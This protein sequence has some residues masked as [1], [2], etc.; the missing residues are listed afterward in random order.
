MGKSTPGSQQL[1][2]LFMIAVISGVI[3]AGVLTNITLRSIEKNLP[4]TLLIELNDLSLALENLS[5]IVN[6]ANSAK[7]DPKP[8]NFNILRQKVDGGA[9]DI[10]RMRE[11]Y[12][13]DN[14][15]NASAFHAVTAPA[16]ADLKIWLSDGISG[17]GPET[18]T[19]AVIA[20][21]RIDVA[22]QKARSLNRNSRSKAQAILTDQR[23]RIDHFLVNVN[24]LFVLTMLITLSMVYLLARQYV[25]QK[26]EKIAQEE[27]RGQRDLLNS[28]FENVLLGITVWDHD[29][30]LL[31]LNRGFTDI[32]GYSMSDI[33]KQSDWLEAAY[34][35]SIYRDRVLAAWKDT[36]NQKNGIHEFKVV[37]KSDKVKDV[38][39]RTTFLQDG[40]ALVTMSD[41]SDRKRTERM[42]K[43]SQ[44]IKA[45]AKKMESLGLLAG[46]VAHDLNNVLTGIVSY[47][48][49][50]LLNLPEESELRGPIETIKDAGHRAA[51]IVLDLLTVARGVATEKEPLGLNQLITDYLQTPEY[52]KLKQFHPSVT[53]KTLFDKSLRNINGS[54]VHIRKSIMNLVSNASEAIGG[55][56]IVTIS[57]KNKY[58]D[59]PLAGYDDVQS[60][61]YVVLSVSDDGPGIAVDDIERIFEPFYTKKVL[62]RSG[63]G[64]GLAVVWNVVQDH[65]GYINVKSNGRITTFNLYFPVS[66]EAIP[67]RDL[68][69]PFEYYKGNGESILVVDD[70]KNQREFACKALEQLGYVVT[71]VSGGEEAVE[72]LKQHSVDLVLLD[73]IMDPG[74]N[75]RETYEK[76]ITINPGQK[77]IIASGFAETKEV[78]K[79]QELGAGRYIRKPFSLENIGMAVKEELEFTL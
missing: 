26:K 78:K 77:A 56:G 31:F 58:I 3:T 11:T 4:N 36:E 69:R 68:P 35:D 64:L 19:T 72:Y 2:W 5:E 42:L 12:V 7:N 37:C 28:L 14:L 24:V 54:H 1:L 59:T 63:T 16:I 79:A 21:S 8:E 66:R 30:R 33:K 47:P 40:R 29:G 32:T 23:A 65:D 48:E 60:G 15:I 43:E 57:T 13:F 71:P 74:I 41:I 17:F 6:A 53:V 44:E 55:T 27:L 50:L 62:G 75:G 76:I 61:E 34:P 18:R 45:R 49:L 38:E 10:V 25:L 20:F 39:F 52:Q 46:G 73:M 51:A 70:V 67:V 9:E 22:Y